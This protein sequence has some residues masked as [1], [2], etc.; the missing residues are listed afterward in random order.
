MEMNKIHEYRG[1]KFNIKVELNHTVEKRP[2]GLRQHKI[3]L[4]DMG[5]TN[6]YK[7]TLCKTDNMIEY[8][9]NMMEDA[10]KWVDERIDESKSYEVKLLEKMGFKK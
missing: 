2:D 10:E 4:N 3:T 6:Y 9:H 1:F 5:P 7:T 8:I